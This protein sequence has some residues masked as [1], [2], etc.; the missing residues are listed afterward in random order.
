MSTL[1]TP[2]TSASCWQWCT[3]SKLEPSLCNLMGHDPCSEEEVKS[4]ADA[5]V[6]QGM[7]TLGYKYVALDDC[8][9][10]KSRDA[11]GRLQAEVQVPLGDEGA[12][13]LRAWEG[14]IFWAVHLPRRQNMQGRPAGFV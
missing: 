1:A 2:L 8:W 14:A 6:A 10:A 13:G 9:S 5:I 7:D 4:A 3:G 11:E 12:G